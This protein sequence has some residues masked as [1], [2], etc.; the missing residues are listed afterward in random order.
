MVAIV[1]NFENQKFQLIGGPIRQ[2]ETQLSFIEVNWLRLMVVKF[3]GQDLVLKTS[4]L[5]Q[6]RISKSTCR[7]LQELMAIWIRM[8]SH[9]FED[10]SINSKATAKSFRRSSE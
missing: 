3:F 9:I 4:A 2:M 5:E 7:F 6:K 10:S 1:S 8:M